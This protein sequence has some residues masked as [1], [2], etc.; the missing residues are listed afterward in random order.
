M[1]S[2]VCQFFQRGIC[3]FGSDCKFQHTSSNQETST[4]H[5][6]SGPHAKSA[7][8]SGGQRHR[9]DCDAPLPA[10]PG[11]PGQPRAAGSGQHAKGKEAR[12]SMSNGQRTN[13]AATSTR[14]LDR[15]HGR[16]NDNTKSIKKSCRLCGR[17]VKDIDSASFSC[18]YGQLKKDYPIF[19]SG[20]LINYCINGKSKWKISGKS[21]ISNNS[22]FSITELSKAVERDILTLL[23]GITVASLR[24]VRMHGHGT[25]PW[26]VRASDLTSSGSL[27]DCF[28]SKANMF[29]APRKLTSAAIG[30]VLH[31][32]LDQGCEAGRMGRSWGIAKSKFATVD[33]VGL[34]IRVNGSCDAVYENQYPVELKT[35]DDMSDVDSGK[36][37]SWLLQIAIYQSLYTD[38]RAVLIIVSRK[39]FE[40]RAFEVH[41][42]N[43][44]QAVSTWRRTISQQPL[45]G[46]FLTLCRPYCLAQ[47]DRRSRALTETDDPRL[48]LDLLEQSVPVL[49]QHT[50]L[51]LL[52]HK[53][54]LGSGNVIP[55]VTSYLRAVKYFKNLMATIVALRRNAVDSLIDEL[56][57]LL[58]ESR[59]SS[60]E[61]AEKSMAQG[62]LYEQ[63]GDPDSLRNSFRCF[64][65]SYSLHCMLG[66][67]SSPPA[68]AAKQ[69]KIRIKLLLDNLRFSV[70]YPT[71]FGDELEN[72][73][74]LLQNG[75]AALS[76]AENDDSNL[77]EE[78]TGSE[79]SIGLDIGSISLVNR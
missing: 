26:C 19:P 33:E 1:S 17:R 52:Q 40:I 4:A 62:L 69:K 20:E 49:I 66:N 29:G 67:T 24:Q 37:R 9:K 11:R 74:V 48:F 73:D 2:Q 27:L 16:A 43:V 65:E 15:A 14:S 68:Q 57:V 77:E 45:L 32:I 28:S 54:Q 41:P 38:A 36:V 78:S 64:D 63:Q 39:T 18:C 70:E 58:E 3:R 47:E 30:G 56:A 8:Q 53:S 21:R 60:I 5:S 6:S 31:S 71:S 22:Y 12:S 25:S 61:I 59:I 75:E 23:Q 13:G 76:D 51:V 55:S 7:R 44:E 46:E 35:V 10:G 42:T 79:I 34:N 72:E 50:R